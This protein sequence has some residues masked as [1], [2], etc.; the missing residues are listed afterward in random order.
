MAKGHFVVLDGID[1]VGKSTQMKRLASAL[2]RR[3][4]RV[5]TVVD[6]GGTRLG[7]SLR[8]LLLGRGQRI[9]PATEALLYAASRAQLVDEKIRPALRKGVWV[10]SDRYSTATLAYQGAIG[11]G[12]GLAEVCRFAEDGVRP[13]LTLILD[14]PPRRTLNRKD[15]LE[16]RGLAY[17]KKVRA[18]FLAQARQDPRHIKVVSALGTPAEVTDRLLKHLR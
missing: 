4:R 2:R 1:G 5:R 15:R 16:A 17:Q 13:D 11:K 3:G 12:R 14:C 7:K 18:L 9:A 10:L 6:P 8:A